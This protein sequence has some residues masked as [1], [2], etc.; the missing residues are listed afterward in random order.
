MTKLRKIMPVYNTKQTNRKK[1]LNKVAFFDLFF[2]YISIPTIPTLPQ[3]I[4][5]QKKL[6]I[7]GNHEEAENI[8]MLYIFFATWKKQNINSHTWL[9]NMINRIPEHKGYYPQINKNQDKTLFDY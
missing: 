7:A 5:W 3:D 2:S 8:A 6:F 4:F 1:P 9:C